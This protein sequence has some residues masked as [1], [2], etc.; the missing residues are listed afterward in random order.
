MCIR[1]RSFTISGG[2]F[3]IAGNA[4]ED[5]ATTALTVCNGT[6]MIAVSV[7]GAAA[8]LGSCAGDGSF[9]IDTG[10][11]QPAAGTPIHIW[12][13]GVT[14]CNENNANSCGATVIKYSGSGN[15]AD[16]IVIRN[17]LIIRN[18]ST[19]AVSNAN[20]GIMDNADDGDLPY[21]VHCL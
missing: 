19:G 1:D 5:E 2:N 12:V 11:A 14:A 9:S 20:I 17:R 10:S 7:N 15:I 8:V 6:D 18:D 16:A 13:D 21:D 4:Y 3:I